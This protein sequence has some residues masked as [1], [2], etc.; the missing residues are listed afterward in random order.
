[1]FGIALLGNSTLEVGWYTGSD[2]VA[3][4]ETKQGIRRSEPTDTLYPMLLTVMVD[5]AA[6]GSGSTRTLTSAT[7]SGWIFTEAV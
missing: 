6:A 1:M 2:L 5:Q 3:L 7:T 4:P